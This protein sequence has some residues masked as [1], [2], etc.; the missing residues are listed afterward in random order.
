[1]KVVISSILSIFF[2]T[3][4]CFFYLVPYIINHV[5]V[6]TIL[7][8]ITVKKLYQQDKVKAEKYL[9]SEINNSILILT[10]NKMTLNDFIY[11]IKKSPKE[12]FC[13]SDIIQ[14]NIKGLLKVPCQFTNS[15]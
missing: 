15:K 7:K 9:S 2:T 12:R 1:M 5:E 14:N 3:V 10:N 11:L 6:D 13:N 8:L 4:I